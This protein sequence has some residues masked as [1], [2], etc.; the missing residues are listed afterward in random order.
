MPLV[1][2][3]FI[4]GVLKKM[5]AKVLEMSESYNE[6]THEWVMYAADTVVL[7]NEGMTSVFTVCGQ[8]KFVW[9]LLKVNKWML[10]KGKVA[11]YP[12]IDANGLDPSADRC[13]SRNLR[14]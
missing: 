1:G 8:R 5:K 13:A 11:V 2:N 9:M 12:S 4:D 7:E 14:W 10:V 6:G 3:V